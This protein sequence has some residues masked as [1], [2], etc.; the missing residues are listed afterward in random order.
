MRPPRTCLHPRI[1]GGHVLEYGAGQRAERPNSILRLI[2]L[3]GIDNEEGRLRL[4]SP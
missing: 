4:V 3:R 1:L 2:E